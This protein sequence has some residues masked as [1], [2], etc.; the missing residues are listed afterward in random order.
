MKW[1]LR[2]SLSNCKGT[3]IRILNPEKTRN[4]K[5][6]QERLVLVVAWKETCPQR[7]G[8]GQWVVVG[9]WYQRRDMDYP[10]LQ[11]KP[12]KGVY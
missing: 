8:W 10:N 11:M 7:P 3:E 2:M 12:E 9:L 1:G 6:S 5:W 4:L